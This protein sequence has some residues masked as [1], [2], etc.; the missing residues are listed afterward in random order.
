MKAAVYAGTRN[1]YPDMVT[2]AK[3]LVENSSVDMIY[4]MIE[5][6]K[7]PYY[8]PDY[9]QCINV[10][11]QRYFAADG[12]NTETVWTYMSMMRCVMTKYFSDLDRILW[13]D[14]DTLV[15]KNIDE[16]W[17]LDMDNYYYAGVLEPWK[18]EPYINTGVLMA[19]LKKL[20]E[21]NAEDI[22]VETLNTK[23]M[24]FPD[25]DC[26][27]EFYGDKILHIPSIYNLNEWTEQCDDP[28]ILHFAGTQTWQNDKKN[29]V[30][31]QFRN[32]DWRIRNV[33]ETDI[34]YM[35]HSA[36]ARKWY[37][38]EF[39]VPSMIRQGIPKNDIIV[40]CDTEKKGNLQSCMEA[41]Q[42][43][44]EN[45]VNGGTW[46]LQD[47]VIV[48]NVFS[49]KAKQ[50][51]FG[52]VCAYVCK[53]GNPVWSK[54]GVQKVKDMWYSFP[55]IRIPDPIAGECADWFFNDVVYRKKEPFVSHMK[56]NK[57]DDD[58]FWSFL[59]EKY[60]SMDIINLVPSLVDHVDYLIGGS[61]V[62]RARS[63]VDS[64]CRAVY[65]RDIG[66]VEQLERDLKERGRLQ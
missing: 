26:I 60:P 5:D 16:L 32:R 43:C 22:L 66:L 44:G 27:N 13:L 59:K 28:K 62:N 54:T 46:H 49:Q 24:K 56:A 21:D 3:S 20:R 30:L 7:F 29:N 40:W 33:G 4:F 14:V 9:V 58:F 57:F 10:A 15:L 45:P 18:M 48:S 31:Y 34:R 38:D 12:P 37:V 50:F 47:D 65:W 42:W 53:L 17:D 25:Q 61:L 1:L 8:L 63:Y 11:D 41:F 39:L 35:I 51:N 23:Q 6:D 55:C 36:P 19:N 52:I 2:A 64:Q